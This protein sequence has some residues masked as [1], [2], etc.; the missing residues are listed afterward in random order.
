MSETL[1][2]YQKCT[3]CPR[4]CQ[5]DRTN[6]ASGR[7][8]SDDRLSVARISL[9]PWEEPCISGEKGS[10]T[11]FFTGCSLGCV[12]CQNGAISHF[13]N[14][15]DNNFK[16][17]TEEEL[18]EG[19]LRLHDNGAANINLVT[20]DHHMPK[21]D[22]AISIARSKGLVLP[23]VCNTSGYQT[24]ENLRKYYGQ[25][26]IFLTDFKY[27]EANLSE[28]LSGVRNYPEIAKAAL[29]TMFDMVGEPVFDESPA[30]SP[31]LLKKGIIVRQLVLPAHKKNSKAVLDYLHENFGDK[32][33]VSIMNQYTPPE[34]L[35]EEYKEIS[36]RLTRREYENV[37]DYAISLG[38]KNVY[39]QEGD[40]AK[41]SFIPDFSE[42]PF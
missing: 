26:D 3:L 1:N 15:K 37:I 21:I 28:R 42:S 38:M 24:E 8:H 33:Y 20:P 5:A 2:P 39:I 10:G 31:N 13:K 32:I 36:R 7:C 34:T 4:R 19:F 29:K 12:Y 40:T 17:Y 9:H 11:V 23:I 41:E 35:K 16:T 6:G 27:M 25:V 14:P 30:S 22:R 18:A